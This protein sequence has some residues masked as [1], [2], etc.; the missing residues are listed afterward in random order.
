M[1]RD[2][3]LVHSITFS[4]SAAQDIDALV[5]IF[6]YK[7]KKS[8]TDKISFSGDYKVLNVIAAL[9]SI[10]YGDPIALPA[11]QASLRFLF[12]KKESA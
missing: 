8:D 3:G 4:D 2:P 5:Q 10:G 6:G 9:V 1:E 7:A 12:L 11:W